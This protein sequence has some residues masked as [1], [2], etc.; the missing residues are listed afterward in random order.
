MKALCIALTLI[1]FTSMVSVAQ[2]TTVYVVRH[3]E[4]DLS[5]P[6]NTDPDLNEE[7]LQRSFDLLEELKKE[8][9]EAIF[10]TNLK[11][12][13]QTA[14]PLLELINKKIIIYDPKNNAE[15]IKTIIEKYNGKKVLIIGHSNT[16]L[17]M[18]K[19]FGAEPSINQVQDSQYNLLFELILT[20][21]KTKL[22]ER[23]YG[24]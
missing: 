3:A 7:G 20:S 13:I 4:K 22:I 2:K 9:I 1:I 16:I 15:L 23:T 14:K 24:K 11:R 10:S 21:K 19:D 8:K 17:K 18:V 5:N 6:T 12:T